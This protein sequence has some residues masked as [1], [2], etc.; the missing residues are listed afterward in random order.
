MKERQ[1]FQQ[2]QMMLEQPDM[3]RK[4]KKNLQHH[5]LYKINSK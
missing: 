1:S 2:M 5:T 3:H 4:K